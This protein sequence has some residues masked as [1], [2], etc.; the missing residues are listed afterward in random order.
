M[1]EARILFRSREV[2]IGVA[3]RRWAI[4]AVAGAR[5]KK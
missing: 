2:R 4:T 5:W 1:V 3:K